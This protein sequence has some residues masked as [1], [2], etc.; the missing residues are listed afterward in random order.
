MT[1]KDV[2][3][4][5]L[6][7]AVVLVTVAVV[8]IAADTGQKVVST[9][10]YVAIAAASTTVNFKTLTGYNTSQLEHWRF[11]NDDDADAIECQLDPNAV[12]P[13]IGAKNQ[14]RIPFGQETQVNG[15]VMTDIFRCVAEGDGAGLR[16]ESLGK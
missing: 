14:H 5:R 10:G 1:L 12:A 11:M 7:V 9:P 15:L 16:V 8:A 2:L 4:S 3:N 6:V 13:T